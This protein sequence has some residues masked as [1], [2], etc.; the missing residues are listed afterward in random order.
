MCHDDLSNLH[1]GT[2]D[3]HHWSSWNDYF[4]ALEWNGAIYT[5]QP[6]KVRIYDESHRFNMAFRSLFSLS[7]TLI[8]FISAFLIL[9]DTNP[10]G[11]S[12]R[13]VLIIGIFTS[14]LLSDFLTFVTYNG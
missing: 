13:H 10:S 7:S 4:D 1:R 3:G 9:W 11:F 14:W 12:C 2:R 8:G 6:W 5:Y